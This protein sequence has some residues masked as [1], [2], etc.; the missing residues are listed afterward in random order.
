MPHYKV[1]QHVYYNPEEV[2]G[3]VLKTSRVQ[4]SKRKPGTKSK[5]TKK[6]MPGR[7]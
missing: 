3:W 4:Y 6:A 1:G 7:K 2:R 5:A